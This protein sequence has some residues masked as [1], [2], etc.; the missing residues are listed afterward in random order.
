MLDDAGHVFAQGF[1]HALFNP[2]TVQQAFD[3]AVTIIFKFYMQ[4]DISNETDSK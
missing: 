2:K 4:F 3:S 1:Y